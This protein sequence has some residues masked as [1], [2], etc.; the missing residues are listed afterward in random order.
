MFNFNKQ[1]A[2]VTGAARVLLQAERSWAARGLTLALLVSFSMLVGTSSF[3]E[4]ATSPAQTLSLIH[5]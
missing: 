4:G 3:I 1:F 5:I 2:A